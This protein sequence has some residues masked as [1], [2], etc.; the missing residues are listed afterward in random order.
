LIER[1]VPNVLVKGADYTRETVVGHEFVEAHGG[2]VVLVQ[3]A[4]GHSTT[5]IV[6]RS[7]T[8]AKR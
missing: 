5:D 7:K 8:A 6:Q 3:L 1:I 4:A 2:K